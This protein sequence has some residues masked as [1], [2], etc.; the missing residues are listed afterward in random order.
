MKNGVMLRLAAA[1]LI[2]CALPASAAEPMSEEAKAALAE[3]SPQNREKALAF[4]KSLHPTSGLV[5]VPGGHASLDLA[6]R[7]YFLPAEDA[8]RLLTEA[9]GNPPES[10]SDVLGMVFPKGRSFYDGSWGAVLTYQNSGHI[11][12][13]DAADQDYEQVL[14]DMKAGEEEQNKATREAGYP[15]SVTV[16]WAQA[17][18]YDAA[19]KA[20][21]WARNIKFDGAQENT[22]NYD[23]RKLARTGVVSMNMVDSMGHLPLVKT[24]AIDLGK[25]VR[26]DAG[27]RYADFDSSTDETAEF[28]LAGL[29]A[30]GAGVAVAKKLGILGIVLLF[31]KKGFV[32]VL[33]ALAGGWAWFKRRMGRGD[34][35]AAEEM[36]YSVS[37]EAAAEVPEAEEPGKEA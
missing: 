26:L 18:T 4:E 28:G 8:K 6:D 16:G 13:K 12:D 11:D 27:S 35:A 22:L 3:M 9:W 20:L 21:I 1:G 37:S 17:P 15:G 34:D 36:D 24:A 23:V 7:Y 14:A 33:A 30:A 5:Q 29:V 10:V 2:L 25:T 32:L 19:S 31:L